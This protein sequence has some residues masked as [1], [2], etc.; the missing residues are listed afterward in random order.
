MKKLIA[1]SILSANFSNLERDI[2]ECENAGTDWIHI[3][4]MDNHFVPNLT[5]GAFIVEACRKI[6][7]LPL[8]CHLMVEKPESLVR[9]F[10][11]AGADILTIHPE[12][13]SNAH[14]TL[15]YIQSLG[16][17]PGLAL[18][19]GTH[20]MTISSLLPFAELI[21]VMTVNPGFSGQKF[22]PQMIDKIATV[23]EMISKTNEEIILEVDGGVNALLIPELSKAGANAFV[24]ASSIFNHPEGI[25]VGVNAL[26]DALVK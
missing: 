13:N 24:S 20:P 6:T 7:S 9:A 25:R 15:E 22:I 1:A 3:D 21:L 26:R 19:P 18:N 16:C 10:A 17:K 5:M 12:N 2:K 11:D 14:R 8:D 23:S 4:V